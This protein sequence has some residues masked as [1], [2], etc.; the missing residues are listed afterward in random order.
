MGV[1]WIAGSVAKGMVAGSL[2]AR[3]GSRE[4]GGVTLNVEDHVADV[5]ANDGLR[6]CGAKVEEM[7]DGF[8]GGLHSTGLLGGNVFDCSE[9][10]GINS[11]GII[12]EGAEDFLDVLGVSGIKSQGGVGVECILDLVSVTWFLPCMW[13]MLGFCWGGWEN[14]CS[15]QAMYLG[16]NTLHIWFL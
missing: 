11:G 2:G 6:V 3:F 16:M 4:I 9:H 15:T 1:R 14:C 10:G 5:V 7:H 13:Q 8:E 12:Q